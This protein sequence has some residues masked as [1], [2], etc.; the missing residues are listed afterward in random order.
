MLFG[1]NRIILWINISVSHMPHA[2]TK[3][4]LGIDPGLNYTGWG[5]I[6]VTKT[7]K[8]SLVAKGVISPS[9]K[10]PLSVR[11]SM[12]HSELIKIVEGHPIDMVAMETVYINL[13]PKTSMTLC[14]AR[15]ALLAALGSCNIAVAEYAPAKVKQVV[16]GNGRA[17]KEQV[18]F[19]VNITLR[20]M[21][22]TRTPAKE[23]HDTTDAL[24]VA[25][26]HAYS[27]KN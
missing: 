12:L 3:N 21:L 26:T 24:A 10:L 23:R 2:P 1:V 9:P 17:T 8:L 19:L 16:A 27:I 15:G 13:N 6:S 7:K 4:I 11:L 14:F 20:N 22:T 25:I 5:L 18:A